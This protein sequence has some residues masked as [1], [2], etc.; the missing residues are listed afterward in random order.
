MSHKTLNVRQL[1]HLAFVP[2]LWRCPACHSQADLARDDG[3]RVISAECPNC[4]TAMSRVTERSYRQDL[5]DGLHAAEIARDH[6]ERTLQIL[7]RSAIVSRNDVRAAE[8]KVRT[9]LIDGGP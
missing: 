8:D 6:A 1:E 2:G 4:A 7:I 9:E 5:E 3:S